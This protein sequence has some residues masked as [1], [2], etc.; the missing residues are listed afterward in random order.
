MGQNMGR[1]RLFE[2]TWFWI[3][4]YLALVALPLA[5]LLLPPAPPGSGFIWDLALAVGY[6]AVAML[7]VQFLLTARFKRATAPFGI[8]IVYYF[9]RYLAVV[10]FGLIV[11]HVLIAITVHP[12]GFGLLDPR[13]SSRVMLA[14]QVAL[15]GFAAII[16]S[17]LWRKQLRI[18]Y[19]RWR[20]WHGIAATAALLLAL[21]HLLGS[22]RYLQAPLKLSIWVL[23]ALGWMA[24]ICHVRLLR[25]WR[26]SRRPWRVVEVSRES[27]RSWILRVRP[28]GHAGF[29]F[30][31]GQFAWVTLRASPF[32]LKEHPF[33]IASA[34]AA[35]GALSFAIKELGDFTREIGNIRADEVAY[36]DGPYGAFTVDRFPRAAGFLFVAGGV[37][38]APIMSM[39]RAL[40]ERGEKRPLT[41]F[42][43]NRLWD[44]VVFRDE[45]AALAQRLALEPV[46]VLGEPPAGWAGERGLVTREVL[47]RHLPQGYEG[48]QVFICGPNPMIASVE[49]DLVQL[50]IKP[51]NLHSEIFDLA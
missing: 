30:R 28:E 27:G 43:G 36:V 37:G 25:P 5:V 17:S 13:G 38:I 3:G 12:E 31:P 48:F 26:L 39:L 32:A 45:L 29:D 35:D 22:D 34:P 42:Y 51:R 16:V 9:H 18:E 14:G 8:D 21:V 20:F 19:D 2:S 50:G 40:A 41:L 11:I 47:A 49:R 24:L 46:H 44:H 33:S 15:L 6:A 23:L 4:V 7:G 10:A 1:W